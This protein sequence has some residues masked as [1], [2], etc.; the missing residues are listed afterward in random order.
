VGE[1]GGTP[2]EGLLRYQSYLKRSDH[3]RGLL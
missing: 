2:G 3:V 1:V